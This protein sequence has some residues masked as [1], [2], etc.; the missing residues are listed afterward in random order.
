MVDSSEHK[1]I[2]KDKMLSNIKEHVE[3]WKAIK[4]THNITVTRLSGMSNAVYKVHINKLDD[5]ED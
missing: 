3:A 2:L 1:H 5:D 4:S